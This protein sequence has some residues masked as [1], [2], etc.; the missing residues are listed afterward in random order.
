MLKHSKDNLVRHAA[1]KRI[2]TVLHREA[3]LNLTF[4]LNSRVEE[5]YL[6]C[7]KGCK[8][9]QEERQTDQSN[10][11]ARLSTI[12]NLNTI[13]FLYVLK[14]FLRQWQWDKY[15]SLKGR[16]KF[17]T[18]VIRK[19]DNTNTDSTKNEMNRDRSYNEKTSKADTYKTLLNAHELTKLLISTGYP[20][21]DDATQI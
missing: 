6:T 4:E 15:F 8:I 17:S 3:S 16:L 2:Y 5:K 10:Y 12:P 1:K 20:V 18:D 9:S 14:A 7:Y 19:W 21:S 13:A 11:K